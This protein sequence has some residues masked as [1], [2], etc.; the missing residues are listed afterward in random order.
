[1]PLSVSSPEGISTA[2]I[3]KPEALIIVIASA[4]N[5]RT[6]FF[7]PVP[8]MASTISAFLLEALTE[9]LQADPPIN[10]GDFSLEL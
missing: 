4:N 9:Q 3:G 5:P 6:S 8:R 7:I 10:L 1:M 2:T